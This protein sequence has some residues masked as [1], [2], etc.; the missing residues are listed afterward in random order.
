LHRL[1]LRCTDR[2]KTP[3]LSFPF[4][5]R[6]R[7]SESPVPRQHSI[8]GCR[9]TIVCTKPWGSGVD[10]GEVGVSAA[11]G[12]NG[13]TSETSYWSV[14]SNQPI[15]RTNSDAKHPF[16]CHRER[17]GGADVTKSDPP[18]FRLQRPGSILLKHPLVRLSSRFLPAITRACMYCTCFVR[19][20]LRIIE[21]CLF[22]YTRVLDYYPRTSRV[23]KMLSLISADSSRNPLSVYLY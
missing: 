18:A 20:A 13:I 6:R 19:N 14:R 22:I 5:L 11:W 8:L 3:N 16:T 21:C 1:R 15:Q 4:R 2:R 10:P 9:R 12:T 23:A 17:D 7:E